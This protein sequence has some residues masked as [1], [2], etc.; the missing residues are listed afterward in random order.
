VLRG[1]ETLKAMLKLLPAKRLVPLASASGSGA[2]KGA[3]LFGIVVFFL[4]IGWMLDKAFG[5]KPVFMVSLVV[6]GFVGSLLRTWYAYDADMR[7][8]ETKIG[9]SS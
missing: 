1:P 2:A 8:Q 6:L 7:D 5:T 9:R 3:D 4:G